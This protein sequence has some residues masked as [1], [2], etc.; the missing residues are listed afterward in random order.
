MITSHNYHPFYGE[1]HEKFPPTFHHTFPPLPLHSP[2]SMVG[3]KTTP[4]S[5]FSPSCLRKRE[6]D[7]LPPHPA[8]PPPRK[9]ELFSPPHPA[10][11][12][13][14][15]EEILLLLLLLLLKSRLLLSL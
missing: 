3:T 8:P 12:K 4:S 13:F 6:S 10:P 9:R 11:R 15:R 5:S 1:A 7:P 2:F 14:E